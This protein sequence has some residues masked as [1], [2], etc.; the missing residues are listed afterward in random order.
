[1]GESGILRAVVTGGKKKEEER[2]IHLQ[3]SGDMSHWLF[4]HVNQQ[5]VCPSQF[6]A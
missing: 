5:S 6:L 3:A 1:M 4:E 2:D